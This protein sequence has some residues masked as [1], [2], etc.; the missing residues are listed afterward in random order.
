MGQL[1]RRISAIPRMPVPIRYLCEKNIYF[2]SHK[3]PQRITQSI[4]ENN[5]PEL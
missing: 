1:K 3:G 5:I 4:T 2:T